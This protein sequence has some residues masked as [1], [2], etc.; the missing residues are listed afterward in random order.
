MLQRTTRQ[1]SPDP[2]RRGLLPALPE[3]A[4]RAGGRRRRVPQSAPSGLLRVDVQ[5]AW[6][7]GSC[8]RACRSSWP[9]IPRSRSR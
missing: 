8:C 6:R 1:V 7:G 5:G 2:G 9:P 3:P 4:G